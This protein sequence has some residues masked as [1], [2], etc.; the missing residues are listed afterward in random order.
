MEWGSRNDPS[1]ECV[2]RIQ[3]QSTEVE[4]VRPLLVISERSRPQSPHRNRGSEMVYNGITP[5]RRYRD[6]TSEHCRTHCGSPTSV[7]GCRGRSDVLAVVVPNT[8]HGR[9]PGVLCPT[10]PNPPD[11]TLRLSVLNPTGT[12]RPRFQVW[13][14]ERKLYKGRVSGTVRPGHHPPRR[15]P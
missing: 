2:E 6:R 8:E 15:G 12:G 14:V 11:V 13:D 9:D 4:R 10:S 5:E 7:Q 1:L 3:P